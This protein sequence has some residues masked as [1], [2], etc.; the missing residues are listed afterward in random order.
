MLQ[1]SFLYKCGSF[2]PFKF[3]KV[4]NVIK[5]KKA[6]NRENK[7]MKGRKMHAPHTHAPMR[8]CG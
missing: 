8:E 2:G 7:Q 5:H 1:K 3:L 6:R 4:R